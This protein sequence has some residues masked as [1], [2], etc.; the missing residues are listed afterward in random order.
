MTDIESQAT[1][2]PAGIDPAVTTFDEWRQSFSDIEMG[3]LL[4]GVLGVVCEDGISRTYGEVIRAWPPVGPYW[5]IIQVDFRKL[6]GL[7]SRAR[8]EGPPTQL[9]L[10]GAPT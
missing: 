6:L 9:S 8:D 2:P 5:P 3:Y 10:W 4:R 7:P 1:P